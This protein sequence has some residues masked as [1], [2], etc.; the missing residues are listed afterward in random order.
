MKEQTT[1]TRFVKKECAEYDRHY[2]IC[3]DGN[4]CKVLAGQRCSYFEKAVLGPPD[5][6]FKLPGYDY[7]KLFAQYAEQT[8][9]EA[10]DVQQRRCA[11]GDTL[12]PR[13]RFCDKCAE[14]RRN[15]TYRKSRQKKAGLC[16]TVNENCPQNSAL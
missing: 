8:K 6:K 12:K 10:K 14:K 9:T 16:A 4:P 2:Q 1:L 5:Y 11:C 15:Q 13:Q 7:V 3:T